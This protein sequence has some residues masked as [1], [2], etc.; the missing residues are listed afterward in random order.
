MQPS[1]EKSLAPTVSREVLIVT[2]FVDV[3]AGVALAAVAVV[4]VV[5][6]AHFF[7]FSFGWKPDRR[8]A[9]GS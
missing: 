5:V 9:S 3:A 1:F 8:S 6:V 7:F 2:V 4:A